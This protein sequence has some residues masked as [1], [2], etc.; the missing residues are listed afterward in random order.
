MAPWIKSMDLVGKA[1]IQRAVAKT[2]PLAEDSE[3]LGI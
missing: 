1:V 2:G 3:T